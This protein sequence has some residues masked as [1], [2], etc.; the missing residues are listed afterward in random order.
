MIRALSLA[1]WAAPDM[2][3]SGEGGSD[4]QF[5]CLQENLHLQ[6]KQSRSSVTLESSTI[7][8]NTDTT[9]SVNWTRT[10]LSLSYELRPGRCKHVCYLISVHSGDL[11]ARLW[12]LRAHL[13]FTV[14]SS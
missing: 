12:V 9:D 8:V 7:Q 13:L 2:K 1:D 5:L 10:V 14:L 6:G 11:A 4:F 3:R